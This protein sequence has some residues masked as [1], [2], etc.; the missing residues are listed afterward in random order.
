MGSVFAIEV[1][2]PGESDNTAGDPVEAIGRIVIG[3]FEENFSI[4]LGFWD[5]S[6]Y[7]QS[8]KRAYHVIRN[9]PH[10][11]SCLM[12][13]MTDPEQSNF[14]VCWPLYRENE[15]VHI[16][17]SLIFLDELEVDFDVEEPWVPVGPRRL[18]NEDG[19]EISEWTASME[20]LREF[21]E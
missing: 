6:E 20:S 12:V 15:E 19:A 10:S 4:P 11:R 9:S 13:A 1:G 18:L 16:Q 7:R 5:L 3:D 21:F 14:L 2:A 8:W 17:N